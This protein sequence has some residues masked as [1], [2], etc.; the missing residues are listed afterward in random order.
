[1][2]IAECGSQKKSGKTASLILEKGAL[3]VIAFDRELELK[4][5]IILI[6]ELYN[7]SEYVGMRL[8]EAIRKAI[9]KIDGLKNGIFYQSTNGWQYYP[10]R[11]CAWG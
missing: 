1:V 7:N 10:N 9:E 3:G 5:V 8:Q 11:Q 6:E 4:K 2:F